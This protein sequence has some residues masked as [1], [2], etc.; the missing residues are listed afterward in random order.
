MAQTCYYT[1][2][3]RVI[4]D[5][6]YRRSH[7]TL[8]K[9]G[10]SR[11]GKPSILAIMNERVEAYNALFPS[12]MARSS[13]GAALNPKSHARDLCAWSVCHSDHST[14]YMI[15]HDM[16]PPQGASSCLQALCLVGGCSTSSGRP[17]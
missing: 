15:S 2:Y 11:T 16:L 9:A 1:S 8:R 4:T 3:D 17:R 7:I 12:Y 6:F 13:K 10:V 5:L 14:C